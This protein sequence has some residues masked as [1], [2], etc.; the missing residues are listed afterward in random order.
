MNS[1]TSFMTRIRPLWLLLVLAVYASCRA[2]KNQQRKASNK[3][4]YNLL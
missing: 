4:L 3:T 2:A 1:P